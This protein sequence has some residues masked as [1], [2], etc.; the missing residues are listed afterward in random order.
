M[1]VPKPL[2]GR[3]A[4][5]QPRGRFESRSVDAI[6]DGWGS[7]EDSVVETLKTQLFAEK[8][9]SIIS[10]NDS[11][12]IGF[13]QSINP[14][15]GCAHGCVYC[16]ARPA[17][18]YVNLSPGLDFETKLF[19]KPNAGELLEQEL[20]RKSYACKVIH[21]GG[22]TDPYQPVEKDLRITRDVLDVLLRF[23]HPASVITKGAALMMRDLDLYQR[24]SERGLI[25]V[26]VSVT[27]LDDQLKRTLE[28]RTSSAS[29]RLRL[30]RHLTDIGV[31]VTVMAAPMIPFVNDAELEA[32]LEAAAE[33]GA[34]HAGYVMLRL[35]H[36]VKDIFRAWLDA[37]MPDRAHHVMS[38]VQQMQG[39]RDYNPEFGTRQKGTGNYAMLVAQRFRIA[40]KRLGLNQDERGTLDTSQ[41]CLPPTTGDQLSLI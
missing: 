25:R 10:R 3:G 12:D 35:P 16:Y 32:I 22:N 23:K 33:A 13:D 29:M 31:P 21:I 18:S 7:L 26:A 28:P 24:F 36:E 4:V 5:S 15:R 34:R 1:F 14:Y 9:K 17:H 30:I 20:R 2:K 38:L 40:C 27:S 11:P 39:G 19:Y 41:F 6:D 37:H 8:S